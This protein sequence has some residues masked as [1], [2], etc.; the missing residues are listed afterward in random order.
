MLSELSEFVLSDI[1]KNLTIP[2]TFERQYLS[3]D[4]HRIAENI[5]N[6]Q[7]KYPLLY[8]SFSV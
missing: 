7:M 5:W 1:F 8:S 4:I 6:R 3:L 2:Q